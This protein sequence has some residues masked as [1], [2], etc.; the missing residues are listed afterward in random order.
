MHARPEKTAL[1][2]AQETVR[3]VRDRLMAFTDPRNFGAELKRNALI[4][5]RD[6]VKSCPS[7]S[8]AE[9]LAEELRQSVDSGVGN[10]H[11]MAMLAMVYI[12]KHYP[13]HKMYFMHTLIGDHAFVLIRPNSAK[14]RLRGAVLCDPFLNIA[15]FQKTSQSEIDAVNQSLLRGAETYIKHYQDLMIAAQSTCVK[16]GEILEHE[17]EINDAMVVILEQATLLLLSATKNRDPDLF[18]QCVTQLK[19]GPLHF[20][21]WAN[22]SKTLPKINQHFCLDSEIKIDAGMTDEHDELVHEA[23]SIFLDPVVRVGNPFFGHAAGA[24]FT[25]PKGCCAIT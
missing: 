23:I 20:F 9:K 8:E 14:E 6:K 21:E 11:E 3:W 5:I 22:E 15:T 7:L 12:Q 4:S 17:R 13:E 18:T 1:E 19:P 16:G 25:S 2:V 10:C 24:F